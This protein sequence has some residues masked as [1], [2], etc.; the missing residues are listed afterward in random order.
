MLCADLSMV[1]NY[2]PDVSLTKLKLHLLCSSLVPFVIRLT[3]F[4]LDFR[5]KIWQNHQELEI[6][7]H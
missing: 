2:S 3:F 6:H 5:L 7:P 1:S 4:H